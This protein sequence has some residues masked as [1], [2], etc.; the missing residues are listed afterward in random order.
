MKLETEPVSN[1]YHTRILITELYWIRLKIHEGIVEKK[2]SARAVVCKDSGLPLAETAPL[3]SAELEL[4]RQ[5][6]SAVFRFVTF[7]DVEVEATAL[8]SDTTF[9]LKVIAAGFG[10]DGRGKIGGGVCMGRFQ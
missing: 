5:T 9:G 3:I 1:R 7:P 4:S 10:T 2:A 8:V 6:A